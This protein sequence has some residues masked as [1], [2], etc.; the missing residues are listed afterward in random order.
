MLKYN[1]LNIFKFKHFSI[2]IIN[3]IPLQKYLAIYKFSNFL[4]RISKHVERT[5]ADYNTRNEL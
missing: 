5:L 4:Y 3:I 2:S 1:T